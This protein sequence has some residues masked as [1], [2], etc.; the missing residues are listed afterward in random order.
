MI[1]LV[2]VYMDVPTTGFEPARL[3]ALPPQGSMSTNS[4]TWVFRTNI[5]IKMKNGH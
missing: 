5:K 1:S 3:A 2:T 4:T